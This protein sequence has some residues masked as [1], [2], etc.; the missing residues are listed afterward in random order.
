[1]HFIIASLLL[2]EKWLTYADV[3]LVSLGQCLSSFSICTIK[4]TWECARPQLNKRR[5]RESAFILKYGISIECVEHTNMVLTGAVWSHPSHESALIC[6]C[7]WLVS[8][9]RS[10]SQLALFF[11]LESSL[12]FLT[13]GQKRH[14]VETHHKNEIH[15]Y[16]LMVDQKIIYS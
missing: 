13:F 8:R 5:L 9:R 14:A 12:D 16:S 1:M 10:K 15:M 4:R 6:P 7:R 11:S 2:V 3:R